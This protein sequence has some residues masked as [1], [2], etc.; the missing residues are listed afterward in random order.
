MC[1]DNEIKNS[2]QLKTLFTALI[3]QAGCK[4]IFVQWFKPTVFLQTF[5]L[6]PLSISLRFV[7]V[8]FASRSCNWIIWVKLFWK[9]ELN[10]WQLH[11]PYLNWLIFYYYL[12]T[13]G[14]AI[15][16]IKSRI[17]D[18]KNYQNKQAVRVHEIQLKHF[19]LD[20]NMYLKKFC[21]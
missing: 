6:L 3:F 17:S 1:L 2:F 19:Y 21:I 14:M 11:L 13:Y 20:L 15:W 16:H 7:S 10:S 18:L 4:D 9:S 5:Y 8:L 12:F